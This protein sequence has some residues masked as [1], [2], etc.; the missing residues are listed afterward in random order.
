LRTIFSTPLLGGERHRDE[1][2]ID[3]VEAGE[4]DE[5]LDAPKLWNAGNDRWC[6]IV[7]AKSRAAFAN[8]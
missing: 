5:I 1:H 7:R 4:Q 2:E 3:L 8:G 6:A